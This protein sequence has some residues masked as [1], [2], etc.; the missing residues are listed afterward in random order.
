MASNSQIGQIGGPVTFIRKTRA[1]DFSRDDIQCAALER[2]P[3]LVDCQASKA[4]LRGM[5]TS[6]IMAPKHV[7]A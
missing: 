4:D 2:P 1:T 6:V 3:F 5:K 7:S